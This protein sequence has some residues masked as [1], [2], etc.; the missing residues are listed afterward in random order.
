M[1]AVREALG[2]LDL[3]VWRWH[4]SREWRLRRDAEQRR[5]S[6]GGMFKMGGKHRCAIFLKLDPEKIEKTSKLSAYRRLPNPRTSLSA[7]SLALLA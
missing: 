1:F 3:I 4:A 7:R 6:A 2:S 5:R